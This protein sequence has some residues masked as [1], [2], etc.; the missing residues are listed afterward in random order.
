MVEHILCTR[1]LLKLFADKLFLLQNEEGPICLAFFEQALDSESAI[2]VL[3]DEPGL[4]NANHASESLHIE[5]S[6]ILLA[7]SIHVCTIDSNSLALVRRARSFITYQ[8]F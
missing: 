3:G 4:K 8:K 5:N 1:S 2:V 7:D 6:L